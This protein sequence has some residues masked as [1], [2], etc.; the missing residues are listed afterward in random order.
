MPS[1]ATNADK[2]LYIQKTKPW[3]EKI[4][5][6]KEKEK[7]LISMTQ[8]YPE[9]AP[10]AHLALADE[11][12]NLTECQIEIASLSMEYLLAK[13]EELLNE[14]RKNIYR[15]L[16][17]VETVVT[18]LVDAPFSDYED[19]LEKIASFDAEQRFKLVE[20]MGE[21]IKRLKEVYG[22]NSKWKWSFVEADGRYAAVAKNI[23][24]LKKVVSNTD[25]RSP[26]YEPTVRHLQ[27]VK[28]NLKHAA[29]RYREKYEMSSNNIDDFRKGINFLRSLF[30]IHTLTGEKDA[31][32]AVKKK[33][34]IWKAKLET[35]IKNNKAVN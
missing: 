35:D 30:R 18:D 23:L 7:N 12:L 25:P 24:D 27:A 14:A 6:I 22:D 33:H 26:H 3:E 17:Y 4:E 21:I 15:S 34:E 2:I 8:E 11:M 28:E 16:K 31:A 13:N 19:Y 29:D 20:K 1:K 5:E 10:I 9:E 32:V